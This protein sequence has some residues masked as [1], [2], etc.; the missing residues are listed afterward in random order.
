VPVSIASVGTRDVGRYLD[1]LGA[2]T[3]LNTVTV[4]SRVDGQLMTV[5]FQEG[6]LVRRGDLLAEIDSLHRF[7][8]DTG[9]DDP[10]A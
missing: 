4:K 3:A 10:N 2:V 9:S 6:Q 5:R 8:L 1:G 7:H